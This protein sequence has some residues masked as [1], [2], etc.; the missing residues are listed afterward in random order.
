MSREDESLFCDLYS[1][2]E[3]MRF[4]GPPLAR[5][6]AARAFHSLLRSMRDSEAD[7]VFFTISDT[8]SRD[9]LGICSLQHIDRQ[10]RRS[11]AG[12]IIGSNYRSRGCAREGLSG[13][14]RF[15]FDTL[16]IDE[17][18]VQIAVDHTVVEK[19]VISVGLARGAQTT[20]NGGQIA[21]RIWSARRES[22]PENL[23]PGKSTP[24]N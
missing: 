4:I 14:I 22:W 9:T 21:T 23:D 12:I 18:W 15:A 11:E 13:L 24:G 20:A 8:R 5:E 16:P 10:G 6:R 1:D 17:V 7:Q 2:A 19:L 3:T